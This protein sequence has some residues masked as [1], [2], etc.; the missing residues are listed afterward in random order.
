MKKEKS[1]LSK[2]RGIKKK[3][4]R[5]IIKDVTNEKIREN[6]NKIRNIKNEEKS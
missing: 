3:R 5:K 1:T 6:V 2:G 4:R